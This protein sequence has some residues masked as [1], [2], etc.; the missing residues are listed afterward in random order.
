MKVINLFGEPCSG[1][2]TTRARLFYEMKVS[3]Y[4][5][6]EI[7]EYA[8][9][10]VWEERNNIINDQLYILAKQNRKLINVQNKVNWCITDSPLLLNMIY[11]KNNTYRTYNNTLQKM[12]IDTFLSYDNINILLKR[13]HKYQTIGRMQNEDEA[14]KIGISIKETLCNLEIPF[15]EI[16]SDDVTIDL[17]K[18]LI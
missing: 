4:N 8:K 14:K 3:G 9:D 12:I 2:S 17:I 15:I 10:I 11:L 7:T 5:V 6:E 1:K 13:N 18:T 16:N